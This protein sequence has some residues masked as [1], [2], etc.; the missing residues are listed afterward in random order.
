M[1]IFEKKLEYPVRVGGPNPRLAKVIITQYGGPD[2]ELAASL[3]YLTQRYTMP[4]P[5]AKAVLT[6]IGT[7]ELA[8]MEIVATL[9]YNLIKDAPLEE[10]KR[11][12]LDGYYADH[13]RALYFVNAAGAPWTATYIQS[14]GDPVTDLHENMAAEQKARS[15]YEYLIQLSDDP[16]VSDTLKFLREREIVHFQRFGETLNLVH[17][18]LDRKKYY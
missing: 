14:K 8:H 9:V 6:D 1:W 10:I 17:E 2:G 3:R 11:A 13:D 16:D 4:L 7:E 12:G 15:T 18:Y 5:Q